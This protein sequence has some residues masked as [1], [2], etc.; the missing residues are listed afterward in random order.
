MS[1]LELNMLERALAAVAP[2]WGVRRLH[3]KATLAS[4]TEAAR[5]FDAARRDRRTASWRASGG[6]PN[7]E[8]GPALDLVRR[9]SRDLVRNNEWAGNFKRKI[10]AHMVGTG[11][12]PR[13]MRDASKAAKKRSRE[14]W[15]AF[16]ENSDPS[17][18]LDFYGQQAMLA[19]E[20]VEGGAAFLRWYI[21]PSSWGLKV[22]LQCE[23]LAH[24]HLDTRKT[25]MR[26]DNAIIN[27][28]EFDPFGRRVAYWLFPVHPGE[29]SA[30]HRWKHVSERVPA[31]QCDHV[32][33]V[34]LA[35]QVTGVPWLA[36]SALRLRDT[37]DY[38]EAE[39]VRKKI[40][41]CLTVFVRRNGTGP[42]NLAQANAQTTDPKRGGRLE[43]IAPGLIAYLN[44][45]EEISTAQPAAS[46]GY[47]EVMDRQMLAAAAGVGLPYAIATGDLTKANFAGMREG[48]LD[49]WQVL[50][51]WQWLMLVPQVCRPSWRRVM[52]AGIGAGY[53][54]PRDIRAEFTMPKRPWVDPLKD[55]KAEEAELGLGLESW[56][57]KVSARGYDPEDLLAEIAEWRPKLAAAGVTFAKAP[58]QPGAAPG[59]PPSNEE[60]DN[61]GDSSDGRA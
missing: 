51:Q 29:F 6:S 44:E 22:P 34:D 24:E 16:A 38:E 14:I 23:V 41:A 57:E 47:A 28:V 55:V 26:G 1:V 27:G 3:A 19:G 52:Q 15:D 43:K 39:L 48:K 7:A 13:P 31:S 25:E 2:E 50:D 46:T 54:L 36:P 20:V 42:Q 8:I 56:S 12:A 5:G 37:G 35:G 40:E 61:A 9:R 10:V 18:M 4:A 32:F 30:V 53:Q 45:G 33:R 58:G 49:F 17:G 21:R 59:E 60:N 11:I